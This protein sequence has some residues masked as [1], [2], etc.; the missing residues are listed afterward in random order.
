[1]LPHLRTI[2][3]CGVSLLPFLGAHAAHGQDTSPADV[4]GTIRGRILDATTGKPVPDALVVWDQTLKATLTDSVGR[5]ELAGLEGAGF[6]SVDHYGYE[7]AAWRARITAPLLDVG[8]LRLPP[9]PVLVG[10]ISV[11]AE[12]VASIEQQLRTRRR[13]APVTTRAFGRRQLL[14][15]AAR[16]IGELL[17][18]EAGV[19]RVPCTTSSSYAGSRTG[20]SGLSGACVYRR[21][22]VIEPRIFIDELRLF[23]GLDALA[24]YPPHDLYM[25]EVF[26]SGLEVRAYTHSFI[27][28]MLRRPRMLQPTIW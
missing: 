15:S 1:M 16:D 10:G 4:T 9:D 20:A 6:L 22:R 2:A 3:F 17:R 28:R 5:F 21:G 18:L 14:M 8:D 7:K 12:R 19:Y 11:V 23:G 25:L 27:R 24:T 13:A 26:G